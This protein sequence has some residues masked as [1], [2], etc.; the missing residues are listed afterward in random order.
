MKWHTLRNDNDLDY[1]ELNKKIKLLN[2]GMRFQ[3]PHFV[4]LFY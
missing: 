2:N 3:K 1:N 4:E